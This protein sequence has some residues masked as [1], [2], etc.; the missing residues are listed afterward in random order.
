MTASFRYGPAVSQE[1]ALLLPRRARPP[2]VCLLHGGFWRQPHGR[3]QMDAIAADLAGRG[4][5]VW[6]L[7]YRR[8]GEEGGGWPGTFEDVVAGVA[9]LTR[10]DG[11]DLDLGRV[12]VVGHSAGGHLALWYAAA[13]QGRAGRGGIRPAAAVGLA[14]IADLAGAHAAD[15]GRGAVAEL[16]GGPPERYPER[17]RDASPIERL[18]H[19]VRQLVLHGTAD[20]AVPVELSRRYVCAAAAAGDAVELVELPGTGHM[21]YLEPASEAHAAL[22]RWLATATGAA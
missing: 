19:G 7:G 1:A 17:Y 16:L 11:C 14:P 8:I 18:P 13:Q 20:P 5:A 21:E 10:L 6:N 2:V 22:C 15:L 9:H 4:F 12:V 3:D